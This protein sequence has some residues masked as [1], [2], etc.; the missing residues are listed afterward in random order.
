M[1]IVCN[2]IYVQWTLSIALINF[3]EQKKI[4]MQTD[5]LNIR[6]LFNKYPNFILVSSAIESCDSNLR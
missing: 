5:E 4:Y 2:V 1:R 3:L 6:L